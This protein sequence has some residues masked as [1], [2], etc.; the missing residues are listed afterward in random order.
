[1]N[2][3]FELMMIQLSL[4]FLVGSFPVPSI[5]LKYHKEKRFFFFKYNPKIAK[6]PLTNVCHLL[7]K[8]NVSN[9]IAC[10]KRYDI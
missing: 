1:M 3:H 9:S 7:Q 4:S 6:F 2:I 10:N 5:P 8:I